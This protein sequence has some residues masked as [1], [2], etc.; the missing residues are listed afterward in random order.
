VET[1]YRRILER[2]PDSWLAHNNLGLILAPQPGR[3]AEAVQEY[4]EAIRVQPAYPEAHFN[5]GSAL[6]HSGI[7]EQQPEAI[8]EYETALRIRPDYVEAHY[9]LANLLAVMPGRLPDAIAEYQKALPAS[10]DT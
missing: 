4:R 8:Q 10:A 7:E 5:L 6:A 2:N 9:N 3:L 1:L